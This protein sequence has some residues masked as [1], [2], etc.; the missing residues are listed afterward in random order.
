MEVASFDLNL[1]RILLAVAKHRNVTA[2]GRELGLTQSSVSHSSDCECFV[3][4]RCLCAPAQ[5]CSP[6]QLPTP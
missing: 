5:G 1:V 6:P 4:T 2:A 3:T